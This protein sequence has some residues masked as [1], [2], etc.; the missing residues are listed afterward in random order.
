MAKLRV[1]KHIIQMKKSSTRHGIILLTS[2]TNIQPTE[3]TS[4]DLGTNRDSPFHKYQTS[5]NI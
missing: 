2:M 4:V 1:L 3:Q 5:Y